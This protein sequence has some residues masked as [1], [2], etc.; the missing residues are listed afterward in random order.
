MIYGLWM[1]KCFLINVNVVNVEMQKSEVDQC[2]GGPVSK[3]CAD[4]IC[5]LSQLVHWSNV[6][7]AQCRAT[8]MSKWTNVE[9]DQCPH[10][11]LLKSGE[12]LI[13][14]KEV[15]VKKQFFPFFGRLNW[16]NIEIIFDKGIKTQLQVENNLP[17]NYPFRTDKFRHDSHILRQWDETPLCN[18]MITQS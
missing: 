15:M 18:I 7:M 9:T 17:L 13:I 3:L 10:F 14:K 4:E 12:V 2:W 11:V 6:E 1:W 16:S 5:C 8:P